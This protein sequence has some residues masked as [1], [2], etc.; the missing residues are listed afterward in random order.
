[1]KHL[2]MYK[3]C[4]ISAFMERFT[5][6]GTDYVPFTQQC[7]ASGQTLM[8]L[9]VQREGTADTGEVHDTTAG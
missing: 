7:N 8:T 4:I 3:H 2:M 6:L 9:F 1:M 5:V